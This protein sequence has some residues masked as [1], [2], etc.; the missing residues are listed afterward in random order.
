MGRWRDRSKRS[1]D[2][3]SDPLAAPPRQP[4]TPRASPR[5][6]GLSPSPASPPALLL[7]MVLPGEGPAKQMRSKHF[8]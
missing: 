5:I 7:A 2:K 6:P 8:L 3:E 4:Y 1:M